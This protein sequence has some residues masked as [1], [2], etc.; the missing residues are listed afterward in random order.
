MAHRVNVLGKRGS[1]LLT[2]A[3]LEFLAEL[4]RRF[5]ARRRELV[6][7]RT[8]K[9]SYDFVR[10]TVA[11]RNGDWKVAEVPEL[12]LDRRVE[13]TGPPEPKMTINALNSGASVFMADFEAALTPTW[14]N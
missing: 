13:I 1:S 8:E 5:D 10:E 3:A 4:H 11:V 6:A 14:A 7:Q 12:L 9:T 2:E